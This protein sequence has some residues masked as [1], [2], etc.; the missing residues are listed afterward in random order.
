MNKQ[1]EPGVKHEWKTR[2]KSTFMAGCGFG[3]AQ[4]IIWPLASLTSCC[5]P[6]RLRPVWRVSPAVNPNEKRLEEIFGEPHAQELFTR[7]VLNL[8]G[9]ALS[10]CFA[11]RNLAVRYPAQLES[12]LTPTAREELRQM[13]DDHFTNLTDGFSHLQG[14]LRPLL[15]ALSSSNT[16]NAGAREATSTAGR[17]TETAESA[18]TAAQGPSPDS[19]N[20]WQTGSFQMLAT[21]QKSDLLLR[22]LLTSTNNP[23]PADQIVPP[24]GEP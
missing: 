20:P 4:P 10:H 7:E 1:R 3:E 18:A 12:E 5:L 16:P 23:S 6:A 8:S 15:E 13:V 9:E 2:A 24:C 22:I 14:L 21:V 19:A 17:G 11:L